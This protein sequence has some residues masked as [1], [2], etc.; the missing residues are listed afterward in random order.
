MAHSMSPLNAAMRWD[1]PPGSALGSVGWLTPWSDRFESFVRVLHPV[2]DYPREALRWADIAHE[3]GIALHGD[4][5]LT[6]ISPA[7]PD[8][9][10]PLGDMG[11]ATL[12]R[13]LDALTVT[14][15]AEYVLGLWDGDQWVAR[16]VTD[17]SANGALVTMSDWESAAVLTAPIRTY[18]LFSSPTAT[19]IRTGPGRSPGLMRQPTVMW[20]ADY[21]FCLATD[22]DYDSTI[23]AASTATCPR[24]LG[25]LGIE[26]FPVDRSTSLLAA[27]THPR[28]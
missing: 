21:T 4:S 1:P 5:Q 17:S 9:W 10:A 12:N 6:D 14:T 28:G 20:S 26:A 13:V 27:P 2:T 24:L 23:V 3:D 8:A 7:H 16:G 11:P 15:A 25:T 18:R 22:P 19:P